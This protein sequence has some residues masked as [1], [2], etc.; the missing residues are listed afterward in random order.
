[1]SEIQENK[2]LGCLRIIL[3]GEM[4]NVLHH[5]GHHYVDRIIL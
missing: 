4:Q 1:M 3:D 2:I 5:H